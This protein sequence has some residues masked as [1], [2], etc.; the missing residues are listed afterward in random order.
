MGGRSWRT[1]IVTI[2]ANVTNKGNLAASGVVVER[3]D[4]GGADRRIARLS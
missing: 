2:T 4:S 3:T 1:M